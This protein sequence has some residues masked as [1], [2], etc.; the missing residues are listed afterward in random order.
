MAR[1]NRVIKTLFGAIYEILTVWL[2]NRGALLVIS[3]SLNTP[4][5]NKG[6]HDLVVTANPTAMLLEFLPGCL[7]TVMGRSFTWKK[8]VHAHIV[9]EKLDR[10]I[11]RHD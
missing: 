3:M 4:M 2:T 6:G 11:G 10:V 8:R 1:P 9:Y 5:I 7:S